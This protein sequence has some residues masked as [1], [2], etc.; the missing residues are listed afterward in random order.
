MSEFHLPPLSDLVDDPDALERRL[1]GARRHLHR[2]P[3]T[4]FEEHETAAF[5]RKRLEEMDLDVVG[6]LAKTGLYADIEGEHAGPTV[7]FR[8]DMD[9]LP[10]HDAKDVPYR[11]ERDGIA[12]LCGHDAHTTI[13]LGIADLVRRVRDRLHGTVRIFFQPNEESMPSGAPAMIRDGVLEDVEAVY[14]VHVDPT[15]DV[16]RFGLIAGAMTAS[17]DIFDA[18]VNVKTTGHSARPHEGP[19]TVWIAHQIVQAF[20]QLTGRVTDPRKASVLTVCKMQGGD[21]FNV[22]PSTASIGGTVRCT[23]REERAF[24]R[25]RMHQIVQ[26][27]CALHGARGVIDFHEGPPPVMNDPKV[28]DHLRRTI[29]LVF[30]AE[31]IHEIARPSMGGEDFAH[32]LEQVPGA[33]IRVGTRSSHRTAYP[34]HDAHFDLDESALTPASY[35]MTQVLLSHLVEQPAATSARMA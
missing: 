16:G 8:A 5:I 35:L 11:S 21:A 29:H 23:D 6:P 7:A 3:E 18:S 26:H 30:D 34:L 20:Y 25:E 4:G 2:H 17:A 13:A 9:A 10:I 15:L 32:Y 31:A 19:D 24:L 1:V 14:A 33:L 12:H 28:I 27:T 22:I